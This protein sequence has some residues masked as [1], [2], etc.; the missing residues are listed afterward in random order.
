MGPLKMA[1]LPLL[2]ILLACGCGY[3]FQ[4]ATAPEGALMEIPVFENKTVET[5]IETILTEL[6]I[7]EMRKS[8]GWKVVEPGQGRYL[9][10]GAIIRF[11]SE[12]HAVSARN[13]AVE[14]RATLVVDVSL[15]EKATG[16]ELWRDRNMRTFLDYPVGPDILASERA[17]REAIGRMAQE[18]AS[19][20][21]ARVQDT[22]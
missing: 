21:R 17:K 19:S 5:S 6:L 11:E 8:P 13:L 3:R 14:H 12:P 9:L 16:K 1:G 15:R 4:G 2:G 7:W 20:I 10:K 22:W 18:L